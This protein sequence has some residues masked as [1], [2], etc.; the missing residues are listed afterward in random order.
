MPGAPNTWPLVPGPNGQAVPNPNY[1]VT[2]QTPNPT[3][4][5]HPQPYVDA[6]KGFEGYA[7]AAKWDYKQN[8]N[9]YGTKALYPG[10][11]IDRGEA[12]RRFQV[13]WGKASD[14]VDRFAPNQ[15]PGVRAA[16]ADLTFNSG[17]KWQTAGLG[18][19]IQNGDYFTAKR[20]MLQYVNAGG[21]QNAALVARRQ[22]TAT[23]MNN[24]I[25]GQKY[26]AGAVNGF[27]Q[28]LGGR[29]NV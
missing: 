15:P 27:W 14:A 5:G 23:W 19:A 7:P 10:E 6:V 9:G 18:R 26:A 17:T 3:Y 4:S 11:R 22:Q 24:A 1:G 13:E 2:P 21:Q 29:P 28:Q 8:T 20:L 12:E 16:L 25:I